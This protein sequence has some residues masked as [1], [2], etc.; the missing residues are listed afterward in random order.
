MIENIESDHL[1]RASWLLPLYLLVIN[2]FVL[3]IALAGR[4]SGLDPANADL[5]V[6]TLPLSAG[7]T[8]WRSS[9]SWAGSRPRPPW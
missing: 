6:L 3:P 4:I 7:R 5:F 8:G 1:R 9:R 2:L